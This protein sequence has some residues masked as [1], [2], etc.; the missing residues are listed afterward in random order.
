GTAGSVLANR[1]SEIPEFRV[2]VLESGPSH[3]DAPTLQ[4]P[5]LASSNLFST[6]DWNSTTVP[7]QQ[8]G[9][10]ILP[11]NRGHVLGGSS[12]IN[13]LLYTRGSSSDYDRWAEVTD[14]PGW[15]W[16]KLQKYIFKNEKW[17]SPADNHDTAGK[18][19]SSSHGY[20]GM[21]SV[22]LNGYPKAISEK[23]TTAIQ[24]LG[25]D[26]HYNLDI[27]S[28][29]P[30]GAGWVQSTIGGGERSS[31]ATS[32]LAERYMQRSNLHV[33]VNVRVQRIY[34]THLSDL[35]FRTVEYISLRTGISMNVTASKEVLL[36]AGAVGSPLILMHSGIGDS[37]VL[38]YHGIPPLVDLPSVG[39]NLSDHPFLPCSFHV[40]ERS[41]YDD[42]R[43]NDTLLDSTLQQWRQH[44]TGP[45]VAGLASHLMWFRLPEKSFDNTG[46]RD[47][48]SGLNSPH[49]EIAVGAGGF[50]VTEPGYYMGLASVVLS[51]ESRG[52]VQIKSSNPLDPPIIDPAILSTRYDMYTLR[53]SLRTMFQFLK[54]RVWEDYVEAPSGVLSDVNPESD[55]ELDAYIRSHTL[56]M[57]HP[58]GTAAM[59]K[60]GVDYGVVNPDLR[61]KGVNG[62][63]VV[64]ASVMP[65]ITS[66]HT[67]AA[68]YV[69]A[70]RASDLIKSAWRTSEFRV[71]V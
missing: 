48:S 68:V 34:K 36:S 63:R 19:N 24:E 28:G 11:Y 42:I 6:F 50:G 21:T 17:T 7:Q 8:L 2:L 58:A 55:E 20:V 4:V 39:K 18:F 14:D 61:V 44:R 25:G 62:L 35:D 27:N 38:S 54:A 60:E 51:P 40:N 64:D 31:A 26:F 69:I 32:Y 45:L 46:F 29:D 65:Y 37:Q 59:S 23:I 66:A 70:E 12:S 16:G 5:Y 30:L 43:M 52:T 9:G 49:Y 53:T 10:R 3:L 33:L 71:Q 41:I 47:T 1:L 15:S 22:S 57:W 67:Q 13:M 56:S